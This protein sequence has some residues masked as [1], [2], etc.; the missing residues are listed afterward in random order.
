MTLAHMNNTIT[1]MAISK[2]IHFNE[3]LLRSIS[4]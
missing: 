1:R 2:P 4:R 3:V